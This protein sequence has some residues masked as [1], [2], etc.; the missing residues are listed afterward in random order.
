MSQTTI[1]IIIMIILITIF[2]FLFNFCSK[3][4]FTNINSP[5]DNV[6]DDLK[7]ELASVKEELFN[8]NSIKSYEENNNVNIEEEKLKE[9][10]IEKTNET[11]KIYN[12]DFLLNGNVNINHTI[13][14]PNPKAN[15][16]INYNNLVNEPNNNAI[17]E[18]IIQQAIA[19][20]IIY[21]PIEN[22]DRLKLLD[23]LVD[24]RGRSSAD[25]IPTPQVAAQL[26][27]PTQGI[28]DRYHRVGLLIAINKHE[29]KN[30]FEYFFILF[31]LACSHLYI[32][33]KIFAK[34]KKIKK[35]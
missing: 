18:T 32:S 26:N 5:T 6:I 9:I 30:N 16:F 21:D 23:P 13:Q 33:K 19:P 15:D 12:T 27:F 35:L 1:N 4:Y 34:F 31:D 17:N 14:D 24:P 10:I 28:L 29:C 7:N 8:K 22:Y 25:Q 3:N 2:Y 11:P 20:P